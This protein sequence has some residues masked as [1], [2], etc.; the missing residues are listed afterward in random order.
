MRDVRIKELFVLR[1]NEHLKGRAAS[2]SRS[3][4]PSRHKGPLR[5][6]CFVLFLSKKKRQKEKKKK[7]PTPQALCVT[8]G[9]NLPSVFFN[10]FL[11]FLP[12]FVENLMTSSNYSVVRYR[13]HVHD[14]LFYDASYTH[15]LFG[16]FPQ[17]VFR[18]SCKFLHFKFKARETWCTC[19]DQG[20]CR[21]CCRHS[22]CNN[23]K[24]IYFL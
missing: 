6:L 19:R 21:G 11:P 20:R 9:Q 14:G 4:Y 13:T 5:A 7:H 3:I 23:V 2:K 8:P 22:V 12:A 17:W 24:G 18:Y 16:T 10:S 15:Q 1:D